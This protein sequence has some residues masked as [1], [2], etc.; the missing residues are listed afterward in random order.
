MLEY[1][2]YQCGMTLHGEQ[3]S[4]S[5]HREFNKLEHTMAHPKSTK[6]IS[7]SNEGISMTINHPMVQQRIV[8]QK[9][10]KTT[11][12]Q[13]TK[14]PIRKNIYHVYNLKMTYVS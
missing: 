13:L 3:S 7:V 10:R 4:E 8:Q 6:E 2:K 1:Y 12:G 11:V 5:V 9:Y 14:L